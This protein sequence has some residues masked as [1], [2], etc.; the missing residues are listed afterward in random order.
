[1]PRG[2]ARRARG[3]GGRASRGLPGQ[4]GFPTGGP[5]APR[6]CRGPAGRARRC[7][8][9]ASGGLR[10][11]ER[12][13]SSGCGADAMP[14]AG[15]GTPGR[16]SSGRGGRGVFPASSAA[17]FRS[18]ETSA[19]GR[20][21]AATLPASCRAPPGS[22]QTAAKRSERKPEKRRRHAERVP[23]H[24]HADGRARP[25]LGT[26]ALRAARPGAGFSVPCASLAPVYEAR[27]GGCRMNPCNS[28]FDLGVGTRMP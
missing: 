12:P 10:G 23:L 25:G 15:G 19:G 11:A 16:R 5:A 18:A 17:A 24:P 2:S 4:C 28:G 27:L 21:E 6:T 26:G 1:M 13:R 3:S 14:E 9:D 7:R 20:G 8:G 22:A